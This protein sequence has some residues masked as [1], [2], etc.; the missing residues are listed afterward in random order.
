MTITGSSNNA[1]AVPWKLIPFAFFFFF[2]NS[3]SHIAMYILKC[4]DLVFLNKLLVSSLKSKNSS[5]KFQDPVFIAVILKSDN[6]LELNTFSM[7]GIHE[8]CRK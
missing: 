7:I 3:L 2:L 5:A 4:L 6:I 8:T 1:L